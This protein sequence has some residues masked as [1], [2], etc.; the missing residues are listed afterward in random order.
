MVYRQYLIVSGLSN[1]PMENHS[2]EQNIKRIERS[3]RQSGI[4]VDTSDAEYWDKETSYLSEHDYEET[5]DIETAKSLF[6]FGDDYRKLLENNKS[7]VQSPRV[8]DIPKKKR[9]ARG[10]GVPDSTASESGDEQDDLFLV[11]EDLKKDFET[12]NA[13]Y[14][15][16]RNMGFES[17]EGDNKVVIK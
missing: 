16:S 4:F 1:R 2:T 9:T 12:N 8:C 17:Q 11:I 14:T 5:L 10:V 13:I 3:W 7:E 15:K 6:N